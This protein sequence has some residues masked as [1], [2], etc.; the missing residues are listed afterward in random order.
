MDDITVLRQS[1]DAVGIHCIH[2]R[3]N[4]SLSMPMVDNNKEKEE[5]SELT[6]V[7]FRI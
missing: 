7:I 5:I 6:S 3:V 1:L 2:E 4:A